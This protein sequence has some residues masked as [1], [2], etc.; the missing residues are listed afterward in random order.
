MAMCRS[1]LSA[2]SDQLSTCPA[3][4]NTLSGGALRL[5]TATEERQDP[6]LGQVLANRFTVTRRLGAGGMGAVYEAT[7]AQLGRPVAIKVLHERHA[8]RPEVAARLLNEGRLASTIHHPNIVDLFDVGE[9]SDGRAFVVMELLEGESLAQRLRAHGPLD[10]KRALSI[11]RDV[12]GALAAA[13]EKHIVHRDVKPEN[14]FLAVDAA[15]ET[16]KVVD[17]G[18]AKLARVGEDGAV[19]LTQTGVVVGTPLYMAPEQARGDDHVDHRVDV[20]AVG[21]LLYECLT[22]QPPFLGSNALGVIQQILTAPPP[23]PRQLRP[24]GAIREA[25]EQVIL[26]AM[27]KAADDRY[28]TMAALRDDCDRLLRGEPPRCGRDGATGERPLAEAPGL[29]IRTGVWR[30]VVGLGIAG[31]LGAGSLA[32]IGSRL[33]KSTGAPSAPDLLPSASPPPVPPLVQAPPPVDPPPPPLAPRVVLL[34]SRPTAAIF[35]GPTRLGR[36]PRRLEV[37]AG[38]TRRV[39]LKQKGYVE[40]EVLLD[41]SK[42]LRLVHLKAVPPKRPPT[43]PG[44]EAPPEWVD[45]APGNPYREAKPARP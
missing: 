20:Y 2:Y 8:A 11:A 29:P 18:I 13:H 33:V 23:P 38:T 36:T 19:S 37:L 9:T 17:F 43:A 40:A 35:D 10:E 7:H 5:A 30:Y 34:D 28:P 44:P 6:L 26:R 22:G 15:G 32:L 31:L 42:G 25:T 24:D 41:D 45:R 39:T 14:V 16:V 4:G 1:C 21:V 3:C 12:A 27:A